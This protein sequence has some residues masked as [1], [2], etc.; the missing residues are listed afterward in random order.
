MGYLKRFGVKLKMPEEKLPPIWERRGQTFAQYQKRTPKE[1]YDGTN[2]LSPSEQIAL[3]RSAR[4]DKNKKAADP[5]SITSLKIKARLEGV[6][7]KDSTRAK[8]RESLGRVKQMR[9][10]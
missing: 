3:E 7:V 4:F 1:G 9:A 5:T 10:A 8:I 2:A 6:R